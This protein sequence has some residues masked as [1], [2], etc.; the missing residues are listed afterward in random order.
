[1]TMKASWLCARKLA[2]SASWARSRSSMLWS[3]MSH[4]R[5][6]PSDLLDFD[7]EQPAGGRHDHA[8][9]PD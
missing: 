9:S 4:S 6:P 3:T 8:L 1:M 7:L 2:S 5:P